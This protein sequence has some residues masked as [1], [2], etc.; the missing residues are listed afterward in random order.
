MHLQF[1]PFS[2][3]LFIASSATVLV[4]VFAVKYTILS[5]LPLPIA[6]IEGNIVDIVFP[7]PVGA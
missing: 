2:T 7:I 3:N 4:I 6:L 5:P 1:N